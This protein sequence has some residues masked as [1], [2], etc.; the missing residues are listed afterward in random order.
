MAEKTVD[1]KNS[2]SGTSETESVHTMTSIGVDNSSFQL[3]V[4]KLNGRNYREW[5][6]SIKLVVEGKGRIGYLTGDMKKPVDPVLL[7]KWKSENSMVMSWL[8]NSMAP[9][10]SKIYLF[11]ATAKDIWDSVREMYSDTEDSSQIF[12]IKTKLWKAKQ[13]ERSVTEYYMEMSSLWQEL[14]LSMDEQWDCPSDGVRYKKRVENERLYEFLA[15]LDR[16]LD[17]VRGRI[18]S[19]RPLPSTRDTFADV[20]REESR[21]LIMLKKDDSGAEGDERVDG[22]ALL[23]ASNGPTG[24]REF[25]PK[26]IAARKSLNDGPKFFGPDL[27]AQIYKGTKKLGPSPRQQTSRPWCDH[28]RKPGHKEDT[29]W[30][31]H[32]KPSDWRSRQNTR[33]YGYQAAVNSTE[34]KN[35]TSSNTFSPEQLEQLQKMFSN[36][37]SLN[38]SSSL[39]HRGNILK[40]FNTTLFPK[41]S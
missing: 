33:N 8:V 9:S 18:L 15:G 30:D 7:Q 10:I 22:S 39:A 11:M 34:T 37:N 38:S 24:S 1:S 21:R 40:S 13:G 25:G 16:Q 3:T 32:G 20:R 14:D 31:L 41:T 28:C 27:G 6:Q 17:D 35:S 29:C 26:R 23:S 19:R 2:E 4:E 36:F 12:E 5:A